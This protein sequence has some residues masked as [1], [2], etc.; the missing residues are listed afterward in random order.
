V[1]KENSLAIIDH[2]EPCNEYCSSKR[3]SSSAV[4][5]RCF[6]FL[7]RF[8]FFNVSKARSRHCRDERV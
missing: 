7:V 3:R 1:R 4:N 5:N 6:S 2:F 8:P